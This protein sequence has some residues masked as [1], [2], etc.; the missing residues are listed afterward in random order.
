MNIIQ[1]SKPL[2]FL[3][4]ALLSAYQK[5]DGYYSTAW[6]TAEAPLIKAKRGGNVAQYYVFI[7]DDGD[8]KA[9]MD[10]SIEFTT[11]KGYYLMND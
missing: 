3:K 7:V 6:N 2:D 10:L 4:A 9:S 5:G 1:V 8:A 11:K